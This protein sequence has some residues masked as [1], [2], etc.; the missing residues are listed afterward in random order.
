MPLPPP[1]GHSGGQRRAR[2]G[3]GSP[4]RCG[5]TAEARAVTLSPRPPAAEGPEC[6]RSGAGRPRS[7]KLGVQ[8]G[9]TRPGPSLWC[10]EGGRTRGQLRRPAAPVGGRP[11]GRHVAAAG[12]RIPQVR[13]GVGGGTGED[14]VAPRRPAPPRPRSPPAAR[15]PP[16]RGTG[17]AG[18]ARDCGSGAQSRR[19]SARLPMSAGL[20]RGGQGRHPAVLGRAGA[21]CPHPRKWVLPATP[22]AGRPWR[23]HLGKTSLGQVPTRG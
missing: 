23:Q 14:R 13:R 1:S 6:G 18:A 7:K 12:P 10:R 19:V 22:C 4:R 17:D 11:G 20:H 2:G 3:A 9:W 15:R 8:G 21:Q 16:L 5:Q